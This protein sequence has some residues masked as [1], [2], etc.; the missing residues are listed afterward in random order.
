[1]LFR[2]NV[3]L[4]TYPDQFYGEGDKLELFEQFAAKYLNGVSM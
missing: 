4:I 3:I 1:M 2:S